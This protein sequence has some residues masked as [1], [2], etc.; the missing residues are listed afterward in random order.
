MITK[1]DLYDISQALIIIRNNIEDENNIKI[2]KNINEVLK[3]E[4]M[5]LG[6]EIRKALADMKLDE[7][8]WRYIYINNYYVPNSLSHTQNK[9]LLDILTTS[10]VYFIQVLSDKNFDI[11]LHMIEWLHCLPNEIAECGLRIPK[12]FWKHPIK[13]FRKKWNKTFLK[14]EEINYKKYEKYSTKKKIK[15]D[16]EWKNGK[17]TSD[18]GE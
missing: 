17:S 13:D 10:I 12:D 14:Q 18:R 2:L 5:S 7:E 3:S 16:I 8:L 15:L 1:F 9:Y 11:A 4:K 6:N